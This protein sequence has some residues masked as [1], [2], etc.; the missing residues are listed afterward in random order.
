ML[1]VLQESQQLTARQHFPIRGQALLSFS[2]CDANYI[3]HCN[4][5]HYDRHKRT[6]SGDTLAQSFEQDGLTRDLNAVPSPLVRFFVTFLSPFV[7]FFV[8][9]LSP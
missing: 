9:F 5:S 3:N 8:T 1:G 4:C 2:I 7:T 6:R